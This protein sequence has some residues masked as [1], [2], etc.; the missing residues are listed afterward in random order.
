[1]V[2]AIAPPAAEALSPG[3]AR[4]FKALIWGFC[5]LLA[6]GTWWFV[7]GQVRFEREQAI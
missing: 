4:R 6:I 2:S 1:M 5:L 7:T 3:R